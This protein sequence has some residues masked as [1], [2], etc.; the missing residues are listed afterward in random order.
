MDN[1]WLVVDKTPLKNM[2]SS[3]GVTIP[4]IWKNKIHVPNHQP[5]TSFV[6]VILPKPPNAFKHR[7]LR[8]MEVW[9]LHVG[10]QHFT[11]QLDTAKPLYWV[12]GYPMVAFPSHF[13]APETLSRSNLQRHI[14]LV[15]HGRCCTWGKYLIHGEHDH[16]QRGQGKMPLGP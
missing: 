14:S 16:G 5:D 15:S 4:D 10:P 3:V 2:T 6:H 1:I 7:F 12:P 8:I 13:A 11:S 9:V